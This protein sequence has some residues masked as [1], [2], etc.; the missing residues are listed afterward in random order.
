[1]LIKMHKENSYGKM[2][3]LG[4]QLCRFTGQGLKIMPC[5]DVI[6]ISATVNCDIIINEPIKFFF[7]LLNK[8]IKFFKLLHIIPLPNQFKSC[9]FVFYGPIQEMARA[10]KKCWL[11]T[12]TTALSSSNYMFWFE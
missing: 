8:P 7:L 3:K 12:S 11:N 5:C 2:K 10:S 4:A 9:C 1:M 6:I